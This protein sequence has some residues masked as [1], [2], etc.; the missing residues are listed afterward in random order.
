MNYWPKIPLG[1]RLFLLYFVLVILTTY[2]VSSTIM[3]E[4]KPTVRQ[5]TE[6][7]LVD[8]ANLLAVLVAE[9]V[10]NKTLSHSRSA[11]LLK[12]YGQR[13]P[14]AKIW[15]YDKK[16]VNHRIYI[17]DHK[18]IVIL[19]SENTDLGKDFSKWNDVYLTLKGQYGARSTALDINDPLSTI[20]HVAAPIYNGNKIIGVVTVA[21][22]NRSL[23]PYIEIAKKRVIQWLVVMS[24]LVL[25]VGAL[26]AWRIN[27][28]LNKLGNFADKI[29]LG[30]K[31]A[32]PKFRVFY[33]FNQLS[34][35]LE[36]MR[37]QLD[38]KNYVE[39]YVKTLTHELKSPLAAIKGASEILQTQL[40]ENQKVRFAMNVEHS[41]ERMQNL[42]ERLLSLSKVEQQQQLSDINIILIEQLLS[43]IVDAISLRSDQKCIQVIKPK[44][45]DM[46]IKADVFLLHQALLNILENALDFTPINGSISISLQN[47]QG[48]VAFV[49]INQGKPI[50]EYAL[51]RVCER[52]Y[53]LPRPNNGKKSTGLGLNFVEQVAKL[54]QGLLIVENTEE[55]VKV[56]LSISTQLK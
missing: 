3:R 42:I 43:D 46:S 29:G 25:F 36:K 34:N 44:C 49:I 45:N 8:M 7:T 40:T 15:G 52:F 16:H 38:G 4:I 53:S 56:S 31:V 39:Q 12:H 50:P 47:T 6:E 24:V 20:M 1:V 33:E 26:I 37:K 9:D 30:E 18:G 21:K 17:T 27:S 35:A 2:V 28:A 5:T 19:D 54:H 14:Q 10:K 23:Q 51:N 13:R 11:Q 22:P 55:G 48:Q 32:K 41:S